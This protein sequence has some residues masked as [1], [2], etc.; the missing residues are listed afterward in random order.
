MTTSTLPIL[1]HAQVALDLLE[2]SDAEFDVGKS[3]KGS[4][5]LWG[6]AAHPMIAVALSQSR[7]QPYDS[8]GALKNLAK[9]LRND[10]EQPYWLTEFKIAE[11]FHNNFY[12]GQENDIWMERYRPRIKAFVTRLLDVVGEPI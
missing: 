9:L 12:H 8:H 7:P 1:E 11:R 2:E 6:A 3:L 4:E 5:M 10:T